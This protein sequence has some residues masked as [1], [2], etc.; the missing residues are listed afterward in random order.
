MYYKVK[1]KIVKR[2]EVNVIADSEEEAQKNAIN[3]IDYVKPYLTDIDFVATRESNKITIKCGKTLEEY[4]EKFGADYENGDL[5]D[6]PA[7][8]INGGAIDLDPDTVYWEI[9]GRV[10]ETTE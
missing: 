3:N 2:Y 5:W 6:F 4:M 7:E 8:D 1:I 9:D 10:Y